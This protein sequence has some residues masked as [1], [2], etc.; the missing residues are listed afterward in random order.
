MIGFFRSICYPLMGRN[1]EIAGHLMALKA[2]PLAVYPTFAEYVNFSLG[3]LAADLPWLNKMLP[4]SFFN[5]VD[6]MPMGYL[7]YFQNMNFAAMQLISSGIF[8]L[9]LIMGYL[10][11]S[12]N[13]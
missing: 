9:L 4:G 6:T 1:I 8:L 10:F 13:K 5:T 11:L 7:F 2:M 3:F 12:Q